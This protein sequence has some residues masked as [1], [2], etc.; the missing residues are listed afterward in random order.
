MVY[1]A[2]I[3]LNKSYVTTKQNALQA[4]INKLNVSFTAYK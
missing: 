4:N 2:D 1:A 3:A